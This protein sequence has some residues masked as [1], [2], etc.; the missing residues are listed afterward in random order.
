[1]YKQLI[2]MGADPEWRD[3]IGKSV[4]PSRSFT[5]DLHVCSTPKETMLDSAVM[6]YTTGKVDQTDLTTVMESVARMDERLLIERQSTKLFCWYTET[7]GF[8]PVHQAL[9][10]L[11]NSREALRPRLLSAVSGCQIDQT[12]RRGRSSLVWAV[13]YRCVH[14]VRM[15]LDL[16][17]S[18]NFVRKSVCCAVKMPLMHLLLAGPINDD[19]EILS[20][21]EALVHAGA[22]VMAVDNEGWTPLHIAASWNMHS[23]S[24]KLLHSG[25]HDALLAART[26]KGETAYDL[27]Y[28]SGCN[29]DLLLLLQGQEGNNGIHA[30]SAMIHL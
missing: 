6:Q 15:L 5:H 24:E 3:E 28:S 17:A 30:M 19:D 2:S 18:P 8:S 29:S 16:G 1:M 7:R 10:G 9:L 23:V 11:D 27:A 4:K 12:D 26:H 14:A 25:A 22:D 13:E 20:I 21:V